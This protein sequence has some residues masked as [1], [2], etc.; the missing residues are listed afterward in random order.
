[1]NKAV[2]IALLLVGVV[3]LL[4]GLNAHDSLASTAKEA[5][6]GTPTEKSM[7]LIVCG[8]AG[9]VI[10]GFGTLFRRGSN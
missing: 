6:T 8:L 1:M 2:S 3:L 7:T 4:F 5:V 10:G 9:I